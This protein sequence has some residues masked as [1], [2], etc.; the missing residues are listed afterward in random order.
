MESFRVQ[1]L[2]YAV[3]MACFIVGATAGGAAVVARHVL[4][5]YLWL[6]WV[7]GFAC[8]LIGGLLAW[9]MKYAAMRIVVGTLS[10]FVAWVVILLVIPLWKVLS[11]GEIFNVILSDFQGIWAATIF[12][13]TTVGLMSVIG[14]VARK[15]LMPRALVPFFRTRGRANWAFR[16]AWNSIRRKVGYG[17]FDAYRWGAAHGFIHQRKR[18]SGAGYGLGGGFKD[19]WGNNRS[20]SGGVA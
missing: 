17:S 18:A 5:I 6:D 19:P 7:A 2:I 9:G 10:G 12:G 14:E 8:I 13:T 4:A 20:L 3:F 15:C 1:R 16:P 11:I